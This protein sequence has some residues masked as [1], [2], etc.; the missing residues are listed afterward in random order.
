MAHHHQPPVTPEKQL[1]PSPI[2]ADMNSSVLDGIDCTPET[3]NQMIS[4]KR[5]AS[6]LLDQGSP[7]TTSPFLKWR[8][9]VV[10]SQLRV[11]A[12]QKQALSEAT[13]F[14]DEGDKPKTEFVAAIK[15]DEKALSS[16][17]AF[18]LSQRK[19]LEQDLNDIVSQKIQL[20]EAYI[21][22]LRMSL[23]AASSSKEKLPCLK[24]P[25]LD[26]KRFQDVV[27][28]YLGTKTVYPDTGDSRKWCN[29]L[30]Y[31]LSSDS[32][33]CAHI[34]PYSWNVK[35]MAHM[36]GSDEPPLTSRRNGLTL[37]K[38]IEE[39]FD[40]CWIAIVPVDS[41][42]SIPTEWKIILLNTAERDHTFFRDMFKATDRELWRWRDIDGRKLS[43]RNDNRPARRFLYMRY[44]LAWLHAEEKSW[45]GFKEKVPPGEVWASP[46]KPDG[47][48][49]KSILLELGKKT[50]DRLPKDLISAGVFE[51]PDTSSTVHDEVASIRVIE[52]VQGHLDGVRDTSEDEEDT[53]RAGGEEEPIEYD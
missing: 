48:L 18:L 33:K 17:K 37:Q 3:K 23:E 51:D 39:A 30:G 25:R 29:V 8:L 20:E 22:E 35:D 26:R 4:L 12:I 27:Y 14:F 19:I 15:E 13:T 45:P 6:Q 34:V 41:V 49:R 47:Y 38:K 9:A 42:E 1:I 44:A 52:H 36:F 40:N 7:S 2:N 24:V 50:G 21:T 16:E 43:F 32:V 31:W 28:E 11:R 5:K 46:N 10:E 53:E